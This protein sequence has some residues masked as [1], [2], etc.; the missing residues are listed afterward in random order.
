[1][2][3]DLTRDM[4]VDELTMRGLSATFDEQK[5]GKG[6]TRVRF[7]GPG[8]KEAVMVYASSLSDNKRGIL[9]ARA[10]LR[11]KIAGVL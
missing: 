11:K 7:I 2:K 3:R 10:T 8:G 9:N 4:I 1:M 5:T 6:H